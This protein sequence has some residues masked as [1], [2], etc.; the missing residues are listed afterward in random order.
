MVFCGSVC[1]L[2]GA[3]DVIL[4]AELFS[5]AVY[6]LKLLKKI[7]FKLKNQRSLAGFRYI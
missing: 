3:G 6:T 1:R 7:P 5:P 4:G 2:P